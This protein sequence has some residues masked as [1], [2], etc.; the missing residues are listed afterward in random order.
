MVTS[1]VMACPPTLGSQCHVW[2]LVASGSN[3]D[4]GGEGSRLADG[5]AM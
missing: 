4:G 3:G 2:W 1:R 5:T